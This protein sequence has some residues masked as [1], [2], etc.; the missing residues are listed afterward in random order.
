MSQADSEDTVED[1]PGCRRAIAQNGAAAF[2]A[3]WQRVDK[4]PQVARTAR[5]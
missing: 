1:C 3:G 5:A 2:G 4:Y